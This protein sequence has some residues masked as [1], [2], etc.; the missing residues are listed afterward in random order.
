MGPEASRL[1][2][3]VH[4]HLPIFH[5]EHC[6]FARTLSDGNSYRDCGMPCASSD[7]HLRDAEGRDHKVL[8]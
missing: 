2:A 1:E 7:L 6:V 8:V 4:Q 3:V 5:S